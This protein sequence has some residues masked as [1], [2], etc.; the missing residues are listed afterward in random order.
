MVQILLYR[1]YR[2]LCARWQLIIQEFNPIFSF[3]PGKAITIGDALSCN[4]APL[5]LITNEPS[6]PTAEDFKTHQHSDPLYASLLYYLESGDL[7]NL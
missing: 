6:M 7:L 3:I 2:L 4:I 1:V 5:S